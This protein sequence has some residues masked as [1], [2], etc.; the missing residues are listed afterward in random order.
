MPD[1][2]PFLGPGIFFGNL[3]A[4]QKERVLDTVA[5]MA[6]ERFEAYVNGIVKA[7]DFKKL[8]PD[9]KLE[10]LATRTPDVWAALEQQFPK[11]YDSEVKS[12]RDLTMKTINKLRETNVGKTTETADDEVA[13]G[14][15]PYE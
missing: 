14:V 13:L 10:Q 4:K 8:G 11:D 12:F 5:E 7:F 3:T 2:Q 6:A 1:G 9:A 15:I